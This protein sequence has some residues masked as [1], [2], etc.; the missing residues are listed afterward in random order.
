MG[1]ENPVH[2]VAH[3]DGLG[4]KTASC[5]HKVTIVDKHSVTLLCETTYK[6][7]KK[8]HSCRFI[9]QN[10]ENEDS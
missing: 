5:W 8:L 1:F 2:G 4:S 7:T 6:V 3:G 9:S 10:T